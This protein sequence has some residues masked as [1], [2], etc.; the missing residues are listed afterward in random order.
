MTNNEWTNKCLGMYV[1]TTFFDI[2]THKTN[3][4]IYKLTKVPL[5]ELS[6]ILV[7]NTL[8]TTCLIEIL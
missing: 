7:T 3:L 2:R 8:S 5:F 4:K 6:V 1:A